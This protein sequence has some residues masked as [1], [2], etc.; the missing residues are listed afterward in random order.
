MNVLITGAC[1]QLGRTL[2]DVS[3][4][5]GHNCI[6]TDVREEA[7]VSALDVT[8]PEAVETFLKDKD[9]D[10][11]V[12]CAAYTNVDGAE[13]DPASAR[14]V[15]V[16]APKVLAQAAKSKGALLIHISTDYVFDGRS[17][18]PYTEED[19]PDPCGVYGKTKYEG[20]RAVVESGCRYMI[21]R[22]AWLYSGYGRNFF[23]T[24][25]EKTAQHPVLKVVSDQV[26]TPTYALDLAELIFHVIDNDML[27]R[28]GVYHFTDEGVCSWYDF[29]K[30]ICDSLGHL[31]DIIPC[32]TEDYPSKAVRPHY[33][34]LDK[35][36][37]KA[38]F[39]F[40]IPHWRDSLSCCIQDTYK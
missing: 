3:S 22:T 12:N 39:G 28:T 17:Y 15:N 27:D 33:S 36:K 35:T 10:I 11:I 14:V 34:V 8:S 38:V 1:G 24:M 25:A 5:R 9:V 13:D 19:M 30:A 29:A 18:L 37:V 40:E 26:G 32:R 21:F 16:D 2:K 4:G 7:G 31:C 20:E 23:L 6:F